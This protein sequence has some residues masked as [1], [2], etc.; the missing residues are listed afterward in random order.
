MNPREMGKIRL[1]WFLFQNFRI[2]SL[3]KK[4]VLRGFRLW[5]KSGPLVCVVLSPRVLVSPN[6]VIGVDTR[7]HRGCLFLSLMLLLLR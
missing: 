5:G 1:F 4:I 7:R 2:K 6:R 3:L